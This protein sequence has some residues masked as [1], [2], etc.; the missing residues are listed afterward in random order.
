M[1]DPNVIVADPAIVRGVLANGL[2]Y[3]ILPNAT[4]GG[5]LSVRLGIDAGSFDEEESQRSA[6]HFVEHMTF[7]S[8]AHFPEG[9]LEK[10]FAEAGVTY[11]RDQ[12]A[13]TSLFS[14]VFKLDLP[15]T[16]DASLTL[17]FGW[18]R[19]VADGTRFDDAAVE[20]ERGVLLAERQSRLTSM[21]IVNEQVKRFQAPGLRS[22]ARDTIDDSQNLRTLNAA[23]LR[24]FYDRWY[25]PQNAVLVVV[26]DLPAD[27]LR[28]R[29]ED[30]FSSWTG[31]GAAG[32]RR[33][34][35]APDG[36]R[37]E[38]ALVVADP[39]VPNTSSICRLQAADPL[40]TDDVARLRRR[41]ATALWIDIL[42]RRLAMAATTAHPA[43]VRA[44]MYSSDYLREAKAT[45][46]LV[47]PFEDAWEPGLLAAEGELRRFLADGPTERELDASIVDQRANRRGAV[48][49]AATRTSPELATQ[50]VDSA[51]QGDVLST[52]A[53]KF[54]SF[55]TAIGDLTPLDIKAASQK[56]WSGTGPLLAAIGPHPPE[57]TTLRAVWDRGQT[58]ARA[59]PYVDPKVA[60]WA[61]ADFGRAGRVVKREAFPA[62][63]FVRMSFA[64]GVILNF[65]KTGFEAQSVDVRVRFGAGRRETPNRDYFSAVLGAA[66]F[67]VGG[68]GRNDIQEIS[69]LFSQTTWDAGLEIADAGFVLKGKTS[70]NGLKAQ[71]QIMAAFMSDPGFRPD[72]LDPRLST[73]ID[74]MY[75]LLRT[76]PAAALDQAMIR[77]IAP[78]SPSDLPPKQQLLQ[79]RTA[80]FERLLK[81]AVTRDPMEVT[82]VGDVD[83]S[84]ATDLVARTLGALPSRDNPTQ[85]QTDT[86]F[87]RFPDHPPPL[88]HGFHDGPRDKA[89][90]GVVWPLYVATPK[91]RREE[92]ALMVLGDVFSNALRRRVR[93]ELAK[94][95]DPRVE[96]LT[97]DDADQGRMMALVEASPADVDLVLGEIRSMATRLASGDISD[98]AIAAARA[99][100]TAT[101][102]ARLKTN[103][104]WTVGLDGSSRRDPSL[105]DFMALPALFP[106]VT[107]ADVRRAASIWLSK[108]PIVMV[109]SPAPPAA[110][111]TAAKP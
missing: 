97:P 59:A 2:R 22:A 30:S 109:A 8:P 4:P 107:T 78:G 57:A 94:T 7:R 48:V 12:N 96:V 25:R 56:D 37:G 101:W 66:L 73:A 74:T 82:I 51:L 93:E 85:A 43:F 20:R 77:A 110:A 17:A 27:V 63:D 18:L 84:T 88:I 45:C 32:V 21:V 26:G 38:D 102:A 11:G 55:D 65:K 6:A 81:P 53:E 39:G 90:V 16:D 99:P 103:A 10:P 19:D 36:A 13:G 72:V 47:A 52:P 87:L 5:G 44:Q 29:V 1:P 14:T 60:T 95:Y 49:Q 75:R 15:H 69:H 106:A 23:A 40:G 31:R 24:A 86:W 50:F 108:E 111:P 34:F 54:R 104:F 70:T 35:G 92:V 80:D 46:L 61:Y 105:T 76:S 79:L 28:K 98:E 62:A 71:L 64:N 33:S 89:I 3:V 9:S 42:N 68:L 91:R 58:T 67:K 83:E 100:A 41:T